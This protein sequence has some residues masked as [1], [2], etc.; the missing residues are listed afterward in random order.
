MCLAVWHLFYRRLQVLSSNTD[1]CSLI[2]KASDDLKSKAVWSNYWFPMSDA[3]NKEDIYMSE[4]MSKSWAAFAKT[5][6][7]NYNSKI[8]WPAYKL[9]RDTMRE[10]TQWP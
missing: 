3:R 1:Q 8:N 6:N 5:G 2:T 7:P 10:F 9:V 4:Q